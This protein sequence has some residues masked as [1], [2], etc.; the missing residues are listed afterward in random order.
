MHVKD[1]KCLIQTTLC[2]T[3]TYIDNVS[4]KLTKGTSKFWV[5]TPS[6][7]LIFASHQSI[8][9]QGILYVLLA[10]PIFMAEVQDVYRFSPSNHR[11]AASL[12]LPW[13]GGAGSISG[14]IW[15]RITR[16]PFWGNL[17][18]GW[19]HGDPNVTFMVMNEIFTGGHGKIMGK[20]WGKQWKAQ[21]GPVKWW[22]FPSALKLLVYSIFRDPCRWSTWGWTTRVVFVRTTRVVVSPFT[23]GTDVTTPII[24]IYWLYLP[25]YINGTA[26]PSIFL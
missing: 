13:L 4:Q 6:F 9:I 18:C 20:Q 17:R 11:T 7:P 22:V 15:S 5:R 10:S 3:V 24:A 19:C 25:N 21:M 1:V 12:S 2:T 23:L 14:W 16:M 26:S 8:E